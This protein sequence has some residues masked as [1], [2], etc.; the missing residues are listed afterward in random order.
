MIFRNDIDL[1][2]GNVLRFKAHYSPHKVTSVKLQLLDKN[3]EYIFGRLSVK[4][5]KE[6]YKICPKDL[7][8]EFLSSN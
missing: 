4:G 1:N 7:I 8:L 2:D 5:F 3:G 6:I